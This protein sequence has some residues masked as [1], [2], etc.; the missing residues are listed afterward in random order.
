M[1]IYIRNLPNEI[2]ERI[3]LYLPNLV[4]YKNYTKFLDN[5][6]DN[7]FNHYT[8]IL[9]NIDN[10]WYN[11]NKNTIK[12]LI[13]NNFNDEVIFLLNNY[14][15]KNMIYYANKYSSEYNN[16]EIYRFLIENDILLPYDFLIG[17]SK[18]GHIEL[19]KNMYS[20]YNIKDLINYIAMYS[21]K[22]A[23]MN[24]TRWAL[25]NGANDYTNIVNYAAYGG[26]FDF[27]KNM[28]TKH[29]LTNIDNIAC[30][31]AKGSNEDIVYWAIQRGATPF[32][33]IAECAAISNN[34][35]II[36]YCETF[37]VLNYEYILD[38][39]AKKSNIY[40][41][42]YALSKGANNFILLAINA[43]V[44]NN[45]EIFKL[46]ATNMEHN[47]NFLRCVAIYNNSDKIIEYLDNISFF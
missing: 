43:A 10:K 20:K 32:Q 16:Y 5:I 8:K 39:A 44:N 35:N 3:I 7:V 14:N 45:V 11:I 13:K 21:A 15:E 19:V 18:G 33:A 22:R 17:A 4:H 12:Y 27:V 38:I 1:D 6:I 2:L 30:Y 28:Y 40:V 36:K 31:A 23:K 34:I 24:I 47:Y 29:D 26:D 46:A 37:C 42:E 9:H 25:E 41:V